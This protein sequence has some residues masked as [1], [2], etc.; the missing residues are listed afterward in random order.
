[1]FLKHVVGEMLFGR[2]RE[3]VQRDGWETT[4]S[5]KVRRA[6]SGVHDGAIDNQVAVH[7]ARSMLEGANRY[8]PR[9]RLEHHRDLGYQDAGQSIIIIQ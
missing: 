2:R 9:S 6:I 1:M 5:N 8:P 7:D 3:D 4:K